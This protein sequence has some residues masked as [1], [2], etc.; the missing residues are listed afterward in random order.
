MNG[1]ASHFTE[2]GA[3]AADVRW[4]GCW[5]MDSGLPWRWAALDWDWAR[6]SVTQSYLLARSAFKFIPRQELPFPQSSC[7]SLLIIF[8]CLLYFISVSILSLLLSLNVNLPS[9]SSYWANWKSKMN[10]TQ[11][12]VSTPPKTWWF[13]ETAYIF[14]SGFD[15]HS[16]GTRSRASAYDLIICASV[17]IYK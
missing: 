15:S 14:K 6:C 4:E 11:K 5:I 17:S 3:G 2:R 9:K 1:R 8:L 7:S 16:P 13:I 12:S 10:R